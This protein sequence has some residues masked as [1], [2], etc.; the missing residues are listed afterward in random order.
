MSLGYHLL[1]I[2][3]LIPYEDVT[4]AWRS[5]RENWLREVVSCSADA[6]ALATKTL[7]LLGALTAGCIQFLWAS[8]AEFERLRKRVE[9]LAQSEKADPTGA[10]LR[11]ILKQL[12]ATAAPPNEAE[13]QLLGAAQ[14]DDLPLGDLG[15]ALNVGD[16]CAAL[17]I[18]HVWCRSSITSKR[19]G[20]GGVPQYRVHYEGWKPRW[21]E[22]ISADSGRIR[23]ETIAAAGRGHAPRQGAASVSSSAPAPAAS[24][25]TAEEGDVSA[26]KRKQAPAGSSAKAAPLL[27]GEK[28]RPPGRAPKG[29]AWDR[30]LGQWVPMEGYNLDGTLIDGGAATAAAVGAKRPGGAAPGQKPAKLPKA[31]GD[32]GKELLRPKAELLPSGGVGGGDGAPPPPANS[33]VLKA[34]YAIN[35]R[36]KVVALDCR[37]VWCEAKVVDMRHMKSDRSKISQVSFAAPPHLR[38]APRRP[39]P[40]PAA[41]PSSPCR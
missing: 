1:N 8:T 40:Q 27:S 25:S 10:V 24:S 28:P 26:A 13:Q 6:Q 15:P 2:E 3:A 36:E 16:K 30:K 17:D 39:V 29:K 20:P 22:W 21:D 12:E 38:G 34:G 35:I 14:P 9:K 18:R 33:K 41:A 5:N 31:V 23:S 32:A 37:D 11:E 19:Q 4:A 7:G